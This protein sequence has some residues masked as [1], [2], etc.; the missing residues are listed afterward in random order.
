[1]EWKRDKISHLKTKNYPKINYLHKAGSN[2]FGVYMNK[3]GIFYAYWTKNWEVDLSELLQ[4]VWR[5]FCRANVLKEALEKYL[6]W[7][8]YKHNVVRGARVE[9]KTA[10]L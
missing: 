5:S 4:H 8:V 7:R 3:Y 2:S 6:N 9:S 1:M 10:E